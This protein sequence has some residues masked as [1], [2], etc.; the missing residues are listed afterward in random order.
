MTDNQGESASRVRGGLVLGDGRTA[1]TVAVWSINPGVR[2]SGR[3]GQLMR[4][5]SCMARGAS[6]LRSAAVRALA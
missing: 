6:P 2:T 1:P 3:S 5:S 4:A